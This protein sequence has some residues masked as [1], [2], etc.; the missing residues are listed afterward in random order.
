[1]E[2]RWG[3]DT[4]SSEVEGE[5]KIETC[6]VCHGR[7]QISS[8]RSYGAFNNT[9]YQRCRTCDGKGTIYLK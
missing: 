9:V 3:L 5:V 4:I 1:M 6:R 7:G 8:L 2:I